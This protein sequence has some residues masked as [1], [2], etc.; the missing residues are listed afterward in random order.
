[1]AASFPVSNQGLERTTDVVAASS[2]FTQTWRVYIDAAEA[3]TL[4]Y[5]GDDPVPFY[6]EYVAIYE[7]ALG[8]LQCWISNTLH[9]TSAPGIT[10]GWHTLFYR[11][12]SSTHDHDFY[13]DNV[14]IGTLTYDLSAKTF[15]HEYIGTD[16]GIVGWNPSQAGFII[17]YDAVL[18][19][20]QGTDQSYAAAPI[21]TTNL[22]LYTPLWNNLDDYSGTGHDG[23]TA[24][25]AD[26]VF[27]AGPPV[28]RFALTH[29]VAPPARYQG[30]NDDAAAGWAYGYEFPQLPVKDI[31]ELP[32]SPATA[33]ER[34]GRA[35]YCNEA[36]PAN[37]MITQF[38][39]PPLAAQEIFGEIDLCLLVNCFWRGTGSAGDATGV[40]KVY[41]YLCDGQTYTKKAELLNYIDSVDV[42]TSQTWKQLATP[43]AIPS[44]TGA[45]GDVILIEVGCQFTTMSPLIAPPTYPPTEN[46]QFVIRN[47][48]ARPGDPWAV[49]GNTSSNLSGWIQ[50]AG[51]GFEGLLLLPPADPPANDSC[52]L[53]TVI[54]PTLPYTSP[55]IITVGATDTLGKTWFTWTPDQDGTAILRLPG[56]NYNSRCLVY[57][58]SCGA[59]VGVSS[60]QQ[61]TD[62]ARHRSFSTITWEAT[63]GVQYF[64]A[65]DGIGLTSQPTQ[66]PGG[67][68][69]IELTWQETI[70]VDDLYL[71]SVDLFAFRMGT[72]VNMRVLDQPCSGICFDYSQV[73]M[74]DYSVPGPPTVNATDRVLVALHDSD[75]VEIFDAL[76]LNIGQNEI[77]YIANA[78]APITHPGQLACTADGTL[79]VGAYGNGYLQVAAISGPS[80][81]PS[82]IASYYNAASDDAGKSNLR[83]L[84]AIDGDQQ[85]G[86]PWPA[87]TQLPA[88]AIGAPWAQSLDPTTN[89]LY[90]ISG[91]WYFTEPATATIQKIDLNTS[92]VTPFA[93]IPLV[94][95]AQVVNPG[96]HGLQVLPGGTVLVSNGNIVQRYSAAGTLLTTYTPTTAPEDAW[97]LVDIK[98]ISDGSAFWVFDEFTTR[99]WL[100]DIT[101][102]AEL[103]SFQPYTN[104]QALAQMA[105]YQ[106]GGLPPSCPGNGTVQGTLQDG[107]PYV[108]VPTS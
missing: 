20:T 57:T 108:A 41:V 59:L 63:T 87:A 42:P 49:D 97:M 64:I 14:L 3:K 50:I 107:L 101:S 65:I 79:Y 104:A 84:P 103:F 86:A 75:L 98:T 21:I 12:N 26:P 81:N 43:Q 96:I 55:D 52:A 5:R 80:T 33:G 39:T 77:D 11:Y 53:A 69:R 62:Y 105:I 38:V 90:Y 25:S 56:T 61:N 34:F 9:V 47:L 70:A 48:G 54:P 7:T 16:T 78:I 100:F 94:T 23:W 18:T 24:Y 91:P 89:I 83:Y 31:W 99:L 72:L 30:A 74:E 28:A 106:P 76:T 85:S 13:L 2:D 35:A 66:R 95:G 88:P 44:T 1:M 71:P 45:D 29:K 32:L 51:G 10:V 46:A 82:V 4:W 68:L 92:V 73:P 93:T 8:E 22:W 27:V 40:I 6:N 60:L 67:V 36:A 15:T 17:Q 37:A 58:G 102:G 19:P